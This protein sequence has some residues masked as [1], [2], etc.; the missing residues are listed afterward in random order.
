MHMWD[1][2]Y[3]FSRASNIYTFSRN[4]LLQKNNHIHIYMPWNDEIVHDLMFKIKGHINLNSK[5]FIPFMDRDLGVQGLKAQDKEQ[6]VKQLECG[7]ET[8]L[9]MSNL[10]SIHILKV[11]GVHSHK[12][13]IN[14]KDFKAQVS[15]FDSNEQY[16]IWIEVEDFF[17]FKANHAG[18][19]DTI[20]DD[21][22]ELISSEQSQN[23]FVPIQQLSI[24]S[25]HDQD[26]LRAEALKWVELNRNLTY[27]YFIRSCEL[28]ENFYQEVWQC[29]SKRSQHCLIMGEQLRH[30]GILYKDVEKLT[31]FKQAFE[32]YI[33]ALINEL[34]EVYISPLIKAYYE[35]ESL[36][37][38][39]SG[40]QEG[41]IHPELRKILNHLFADRMSQIATLETFLIY[42]NNAKTCL[43]S[44]KHKYEKKI[45][46]EEFLMMENF[47]G[48][49]ENLVESFL[50]KRLDKK[51][52]GII[53]V[54][55]WL[56]HIIEVQNTLTLTEIKD[57]T[58]KLSHLLSI[59]SSASYEDNLFFQLVEQKN[60]KGIVRKSFEEEVRE[61]T[62]L[63]TKKTA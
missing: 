9:I 52:E 25:C 1:R 18:A 54:K 28:E 20:E 37:Q 7:V 4:P 47:L 13:C 2:P 42:I 40:L 23:L 55:Q 41:L 10:D 26:S 62:K 21:L 11:S 16:T 35:Y 38:V 56:N 60:L 30:K 8:H 61:L 36:R 29:L 59:I 5:C 6:L 50:C 57:C 58:L 22:N 31:F 53:E 46:K 51:L 44:M 49:Q 39:W 32:S 15:L 12:D 27:E 45:G 17:V 14:N 48:R 63:Y 33:S 3:V 34:N 19:N 43:F 24:Y